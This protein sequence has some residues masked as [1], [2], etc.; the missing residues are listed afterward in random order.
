MLNVKLLRRVKQ[1]ILEE[2]KR[3]IMSGLLVRK[4][5]FRNKFMTDGGVD[6]FQE[7][8]PCGTAACIAGWT[9]LLHDGMKTKKEGAQMWHRAAKLLGL[10]DKCRDGESSQTSKLF[11]THEW[12]SKIAARYHRAKTQ[13]GRAKIA[14]ERIEQFIKEYK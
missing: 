13:K 14:A 6:Q 7:F 2:P 8:A 1:H 5:K 9:V 12:G 4:D 3:L 11:V 10:D